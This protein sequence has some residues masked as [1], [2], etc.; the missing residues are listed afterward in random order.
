MA[1]ATREL[2]SYST[3]LLTAAP[4]GIGAAYTQPGTGTDAGDPDDPN[5]YLRYR[6]VVYDVFADQAGTLVV[7][8]SSDGATWRQIS[9]TAIVASTVTRVSAELTRRYVR[10]V[11]TNGATGQATF[12]LY[13]VL[14]GQ[15]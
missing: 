1:Q 6:S 12:E 14:R 13:R 3:A 9:S 2:S 4:L 7:Q 10:V 15:T 8:E 11:Y 5:N